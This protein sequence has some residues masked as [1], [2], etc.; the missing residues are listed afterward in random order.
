[1]EKQKEEI[2]EL[3]QKLIEAI[4]TSDLLFLDRILHQDLLFLAPNGTVI[5]K[6]MDL[7]SHKAGEMVVEEIKST[8]EE[9]NI[10]QDTAV[11]VLVYDTKGK[12]LGNPIEGRFK[13]VRVWKKF[14]D[15]FKVIGGSCLRVS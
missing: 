12:M 15:S 8:I 5:T 10:T 2:I 6:A 14:D 7:D 4:R 1:M 11:V 13:Y 9:L 3:E